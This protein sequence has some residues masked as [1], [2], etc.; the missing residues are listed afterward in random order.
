[1]RNIETP[2]IRGLCQRERH[3]LGLRVLRPP[4]RFAPG[5]TMAWVM[6]LAFLGGC[7]ELVHMGQISDR[8]SSWGIPGATIEQQ[9]ADGSWR[10]LGETD[11]GGRWWI[12]KDKIRGGGRVRVSKAGY[13]ARTMRE[14]EFLQENNI[15]LLPGAEGD[16]DEGSASQW[17][18]GPD[19]PVDRR[20]H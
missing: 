8:E 17:Q 5:G 20:S 7:Q 16:L 4:R 12:L 1:V 6:L 14:S 10:T 9:Q 18:M 11:G 2:E 13:Y 3:C 15:V 19:S